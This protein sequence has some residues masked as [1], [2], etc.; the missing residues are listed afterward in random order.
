MEKKKKKKEIEGDVRRIRVGR[1]RSDNQYGVVVV[2]IRAGKIF[3]FYCLFDFSRP[4]A[5]FFFF[6]FFICTVKGR[7]TFSGAAVG[8]GLDI[9]RH[10]HRNVVFLIIHVLCLA[11]CLHVR[12]LSAYLSL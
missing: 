2:G 8:K 10:K 6:F 11:Y 4:R 12:G 9:S 5:I 1:D 3:V 7:R